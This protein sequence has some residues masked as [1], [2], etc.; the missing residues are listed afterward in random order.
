MENPVTHDQMDCGCA[1]HILFNKNK[2]SLLLNVHPRAC[3]E[4]NAI[5]PHGT[6]RN[7]NNSGSRVFDSISIRKKQ[8]CGT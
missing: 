8:G 3:T 5:D 7:K 6:L 2:R 1:I 4:D